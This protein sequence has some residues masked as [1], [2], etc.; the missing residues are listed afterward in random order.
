M[1]NLS[2]TATDDRRAAHR[3][4]TLSTSAFTLLFAVW[5]MFGVLG[6]AIKAEFQLSTVQFAWLTA[7][8]I[9]N[10]ALW[11]LPLGILTDQLGGRLVTTII[12]LVTA[13]PCFLVSTATSFTELMIYAALVGIAGNSFSVGIAWN[14]AWFAKDRQGLA[15]GIY[16]AGNIGAS[17]TKLIGPALI[18]AIPVSGWFDGF[19]PGGWR[20]IPVIYTVALVIMA[21]IIWFGSPK[22]DRRPAV[23]RTL[24]VML[25]P[26]RSTRVLRFGLYYVL[27][28]GGFVALSLS[29]PNYYTTV[30]HLSLGEAGMLSAGFIFSTSL[31]RPV[32]GWCSDRMGARRMMY[33][34]FTTLTLCLL[35]L[36]FIADLPL[37]LFSAL[38]IILGVAMGMGNSTVYK[39]ITDYYPKDV[40]AVGGLVGTM[41]ALGGFIL[42][43]A[44]G[45]L[46]AWTASAQAPFIVLSALAA[47]SFLW[48]HIVVLGLKRSEKSENQI[49]RAVPT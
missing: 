22:V 35:P 40:G 23:G 8:A 18:T 43:L 1:S 19:I 36:T 38:T 49:G 12:L 17:V 48:M 4:L 16:G 20:F 11:R 29:L 31:M 32:G 47:V 28:F 44:F 9:L 13:I 5:L 10:G 42:P 26:L 39:Y 34:V 21:M 45:Y 25:Q 46:S 15:L 27:L 33:G 41:G 37:W 14:S 30:F 7:I 6:V 2:A 3:V 24:S